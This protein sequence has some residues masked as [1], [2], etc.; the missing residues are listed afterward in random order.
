MSSIFLAVAFIGLAAVLWK[1]LDTVQRLAVLA[2]AATPGERAQAF[3]A[4]ATKKEKEKS[5]EPSVPRPVLEG[6]SPRE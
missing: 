1:A 4:A 5:G 2:A 3:H 6:L